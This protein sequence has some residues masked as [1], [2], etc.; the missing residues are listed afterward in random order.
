MSSLFSVKGHG[1]NS[2]WC[3]QKV[4]TAMSVV[5]LLDQVC[6][7]GG[8]EEFPLAKVSVESPYFSG[9]MTC[10]VLDAPAADFIVG[11]VPQVP[12]LVSQDE[13]CSFAAV[14]RAHRKLVVK[15]Q[16]SQVIQDLE[17]TL[18]VLSDMQ[19][20]DESLRSSFQAVEKGEVRSADGTSS[21]FYLSEGI[22]IDPL[23]KA[24][25]PF[26]RSSFRK[27]FD[28]QFWQFLTMPF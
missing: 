3:S 9:E 1:S 28:R 4:G 17:V 12:S 10:C 20:K 26:L 5:G 21:D 27:V 15:K 14:T 22:F 7:F 16:L 25:S 24:V 13:P 23:R 11:N 8:R 19:R 2:L 6:P 18:E